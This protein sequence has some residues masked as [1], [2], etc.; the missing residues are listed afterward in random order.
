LEDGDFAG[1]AGL[2]PHPL[3]AT[4]R[5]MGIHL[6]PSYQS[7]GFGREAAE[8]IQRYAFEVLGVPA[9]LARHHPLN[10]ASG[11]LMQR[12]GY[13]YTHDELYPPTGL[14]HPAY[15]LENPLLA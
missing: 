13:R 14:L 12:L 8:A 1:C 7:Q 5:E 15:R 10:T 4:E 9:I 11:R 3:H 6:R 2:R